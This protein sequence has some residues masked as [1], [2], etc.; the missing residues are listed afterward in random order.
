MTLFASR[1]LH[2]IDVDRAEGLV[3]TNSPDPTT[4]VGVELLRHPAGG[5]RMR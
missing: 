1:V 4:N 5:S 3:L 2:P